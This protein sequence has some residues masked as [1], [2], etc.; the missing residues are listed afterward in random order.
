M[1]TNTFSINRSLRLIILLIDP[2]DPPRATTREREL[3]DPSSDPP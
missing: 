3:L 2:R 1:F